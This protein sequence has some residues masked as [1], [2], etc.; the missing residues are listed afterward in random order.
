MTGFFVEG[1]GHGADG[2]HQ[3]TVHRHPRVDRGRRRYAGLALPDGRQRDPV[4]RLADR[5]RE[6]DGG[7]RQRGQGGRRVR[8]R[9]VQADDA[10]AA[11]ADLP[12]ELG[13]AVPEP[14]QER[15]LLL[16]HSP[17][18]RPQVGH[19]PAGDHPRQG[20]RRRAPARLRQLRLP[21]RRPQAVPHRGVGHARTLLGR[22]P[23]RPA[24]RHD[25]AAHQRRGGL[26]RHPL[27]G[28]GGQPARVRQPA[29]GGQ[30]R[31][32]RQARPGARERDG[33]ERQPARGAAEDPRPE[34]RH[35]HG[36][37]HGQVHAVPDRAVDSAVCARRRRRGGAV[38]SATPW[39]WVPVSRWAR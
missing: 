17:A 20:L 19:Q 12:E 29:E 7:V 22:R 28:P 3:E 4:R 5:A 37:R 13:Q 30:R 39:A 31:G 14:V 27:P 32:V 11:G 6:P 16:Q 33:A 9:H 21:H 26:Q 18:A 36:R 35:G 24:A 2:F 15:R 34:D 1:W 23:R 38:W 25:A 8:P 10:D